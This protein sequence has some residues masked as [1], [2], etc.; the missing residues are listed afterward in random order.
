V[1]SPSGPVF[2]KVGLKSGNQLQFK[3][4][5]EHFEMF[6][7]PRMLKPVEVREIGVRHDTENR[8]SALSHF[9][10]KLDT[11]QCSNQVTVYTLKFVQILRDLLMLLKEVPTAALR[12]ASLANSLTHAQ[13]GDSVTYAQVPDSVTHAQVG[14]SVT[15]ADCG[16]GDACAVCGWRKV[17]VDM[18]PPGNSIYI[19]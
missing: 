5:F 3:G 19:E 17:P 2:G 13:V 6:H 9:P 7:V 11:V 14:D 18:R 8:E 10:H 1:L 16:Q 12:S 4:D 15:C